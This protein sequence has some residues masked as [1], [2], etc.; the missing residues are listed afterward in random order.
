VLRDRFRCD[1]K[2]ARQPANGYHGGR[3]LRNSGRLR[4][5]ARIP[6]NFLPEFA[7]S[8]FASNI[9]VLHVLPESVT[10]SLISLY[11]SC[12][13]FIFD[14]KPLQSTRMSIT[15]ASQP[16]SQTDGIGLARTT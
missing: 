13:W 6:L 3:Q 15:L 1:S 8:Y 10:V 16:E 12:F 4:R 11:L 14:N 5:S 2:R 9:R 7:Q